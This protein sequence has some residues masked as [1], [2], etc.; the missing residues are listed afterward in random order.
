MGRPITLFLK[1]SP[2]IYEIFE[3][4]FTEIFTPTEF[5]DHLIVSVLCF[6]Q[7]IG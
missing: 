7:F 1:I 2:D 5:Y 3:Q 4:K 6:N